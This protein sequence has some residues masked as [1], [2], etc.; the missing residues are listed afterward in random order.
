MAFFL[1]SDDLVS[2]LCRFIT[3]KADRKTFTLLC[4]RWNKLSES[5]TEWRK[6]VLRIIPSDKPYFGLEQGEWTCLMQAS[7]PTIKDMLMHRKHFVQFCF[8]VDCSSFSWWAELGWFMAHIRWLSI[9]VST[10]EKQDSG[11]ISFTLAGLPN[12]TYLH[13]DCEKQY[14]AKDV[15]CW[16]SSLTVRLPALQQ[17]VV[18]QRIAP[19]PHLDS[20][21]MDIRCPKLEFL[22]FFRWSDMSVSTPMFA[23]LRGLVLIVSTFREGL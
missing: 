21:K 14:S 22:K 8:M 5:Y 9:N 2:H 20:C 11:E 6:P 3:N 16:L 12:L 18:H 1:E 13:V 4:K 15:K 10:R 19:H 23:T 7:L 17:L